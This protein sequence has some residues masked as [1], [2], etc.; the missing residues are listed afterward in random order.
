MLGRGCVIGTSDSDLPAK[1][2]DVLRAYPHGLQSALYLRGGAD[3]IRECYIGIILV[4]LQYI[5]RAIIR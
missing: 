1:I 2:L 3:A 4:T 5:I